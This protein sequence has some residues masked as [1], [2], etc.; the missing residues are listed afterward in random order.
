[1]VASDS[2]P[3]VVPT[4]LHR[5]TR[6]A[7]NPT[8]PVRWTSCGTN[9][10]YHTF[11]EAKKPVD[12][13]CEPVPAFPEE[14]LAPSKRVRHALARAEEGQF[15]WEED[16][17]RCPQTSEPFRPV[18][19][20]LRRLVFSLLRQRMD[21]SDVVVSRNAVQRNPIREI[22][23]KLHV[24]GGGE[25]A[26]SCGCTQGESTSSNSQRQPWQPEDLM[27]PDAS[28]RPAENGVHADKE[29]CLHM[30]ALET[31]LGRHAE[32]IIDA[33]LHTVSSFDCRCQVDGR[34]LVLILGWPSRFINAGVEQLAGIRLHAPETRLAAK[35]GGY[36]SASPTKREGGW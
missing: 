34:A 35:C 33:V 23:S 30:Q 26:G 18:P 31:T 28:S 21:S 5:T 2:A 13:A 6:I 16:P 3:N 36:S 29:R 12:A 22:A 19:L 7:G 15:V 8:W 10:H 20:A 27:Q 25:A 32:G 4:L 24:E 11:A 9:Q 1:M 14:W 17:I